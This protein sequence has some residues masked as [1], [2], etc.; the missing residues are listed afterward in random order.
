MS[1]RETV[2][3]DCH[4]GENAHAAVLKTFH[5]VRS[6]FYWP[7]M[8]KDISN[9]IKYCSQCQMNSEVKSRAPI[10]NHIEA[11]APGETFVLD[12]MYFPEAHGDKY[13]LVAVDAYSRWVEVTENT[14]VQVFI[15]ASRVSHPKGF[16][17]TV[18]WPLLQ[19]PGIS[20][21]ALDSPVCLSA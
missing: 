5:K 13:I 7:G 11:D 14:V 9:F 20:P 12:L 15:L 1:H 10:E 2:I 16:S 8:F 6:T 18:S 3:R 17:S 19:R 21:G 4:E